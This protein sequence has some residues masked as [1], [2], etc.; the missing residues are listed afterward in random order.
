MATKAT[1][2]EFKGHPVFV[3]RDEKDRVVV[4]FGIKKAQAILNHIKEV[5]TFVKT[6]APVAVA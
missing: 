4:S 2:E 6:P 5:E 3:V 1:F